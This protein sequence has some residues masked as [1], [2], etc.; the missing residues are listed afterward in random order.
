VKAG[1][2]VNQADSANLAPDM[3]EL[4]IDCTVAAVVAELDTRGNPDGDT[5]EGAEDAHCDVALR[6]V[7]ER[8]L[9]GPGRSP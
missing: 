7:S 8:V 2:S 1:A 9:P 4:L 3:L 6:A 5:T